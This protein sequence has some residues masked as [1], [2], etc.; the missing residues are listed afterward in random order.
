[1]VAFLV[2]PI[3]TKCWFMLIYL[4]EIYYLNR[5]H[6]EIHRNWQI[7]I[8][9]HFIYL[10]IVNTFLWNN[11]LSYFKYLDVNEKSHFAPFVLSFL[12]RE[13]MWKD[14]NIVVHKVTDCNSSLKTK[15][16]TDC[17]TYFRPWELK[18]DQDNKL[19][20]KL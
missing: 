12:Y 13:I 4:F 5:W 8:S 2:N 9:S 20:M 11:L 10:L 1:M 19:N 14:N 15:L 18:I 17:I 3:V 7:L 6:L 16:F